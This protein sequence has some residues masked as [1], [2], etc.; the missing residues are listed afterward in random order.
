MTAPGV[1]PREYGA[2]RARELKAQ[3][4]T[5]EQAARLAQL[6]MAGVPRQP[7]DEGSS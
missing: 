6:V 5:P 4:I 2:A 1:T 3:P 7:G